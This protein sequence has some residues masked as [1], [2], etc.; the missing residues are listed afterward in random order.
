MKRRATVVLVVMFVAPLLLHAQSPSPA[1]C[2]KDAGDWFTAAYKAARD[3]AALP[4][5]K[6]ADVSGLLAT[7][8][9]RT[10][11]CAAQF[12]VATTSGAGLLPLSNL[13]SSISEDALATAAVDKRLA[14]PGLTEMDRADALVA[15][16]GS[17]TKPDT[18]VVA[19]AEPYMTQL[20]A[21]SNAVMM[22]K[23]EAHSQLNDEYRYLDVNDRIRQHSLAIINLT[24]G[25]KAMPATARGAAG[26]RSYVMLSAYSNLAEVYGDFGHADSALMILDQATKDHP[27]I[28]AAEADNYLKSGR[29]RYQLV[30]TPA[31]A[32]EAG[33]WLNAPPDTKTMDGKGK[34]TVIEFTAH[35]C[36]PCRNSY[37]AMTEMADKFEKQGAQFI[38]ATQFYGYLGTRKNLDPAA[39]FAADH[40]YFVGEHGIHFPIGIADQPATP[41]PG[42]R[43]VFNPNDTRYKVGA[44]PQTVIID[45]NG[46]IRRILTGWDTGNAQRLPVLITALLKEKPTRMTP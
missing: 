42:E 37:P 43:Y 3:R 35:W 45:R 14:E 46:T 27:E 23:L 11:V 6:P 38:F 15:K 19:R 9:A 4:G 10:K 25:Q 20:D 30:G 33:H 34:V 7:R 13:Y 8:T 26:I 31:M 17:L 12:N 5:G 39:E 44:I 24:R 28:G 41:K 1:G 22:Q 16:V 29:Q 36:I 21:M 18:L 32:L 2:T 40:E